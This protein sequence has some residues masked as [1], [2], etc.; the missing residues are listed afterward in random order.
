MQLAMVCN[1][2]YDADDGHVEPDLMKNR[3]IDRSI[4]LRFKRVLSLPIGCGAG[5]GCP[6]EGSVALHRARSSV[7]ENAISVAF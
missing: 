3:L 1:Y 6:M 4:D 7:L 2:I 5:S